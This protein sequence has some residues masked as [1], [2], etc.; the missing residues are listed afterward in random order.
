MDV[1]LLCYTPLWRYLLLAFLLYELYFVAYSFACL[2]SVWDSV[3]RLVQ[4]RME[5]QHLWESPKDNAKKRKGLGWI[6]YIIGHA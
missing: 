6:A 3:I 1:I 5:Q 2:F 4:D